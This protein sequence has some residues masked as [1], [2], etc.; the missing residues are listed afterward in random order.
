MN[1]NHQRRPTVVVIGG[2]Y[3]GVNVATAL[4]ADVEVVLVEPKDAFVHNIGALRALVEP[5]FLPEIFL[6]YD[7]ILDLA[8]DVLGARFRP[9]LRAELRTQ[10][11]DLGVEL[12]LGEG[13]RAFPPTSASEFATFTV[14][15]NSGRQI[16]ADIWFQCFGVTPVSDYLSA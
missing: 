8:D 10:L 15:T 5:T 6:P 7:P 12:V 14:T 13:L 2:G 3:G 1:Q 4:D 11:V 16:T 9:D